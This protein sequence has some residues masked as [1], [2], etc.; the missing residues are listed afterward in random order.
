M[1][2]LEFGGQYD[3]AF[4]YSAATVVTPKRNLFQR[5]LN[6][7]G[8][9]LGLF[10]FPVAFDSV[11]EHAGERKKVFAEIY[12][13]NVWGSAESRSGPGSE[14]RRTER[15]RGEL[16]SL[17]KRREIRSMFDA[18]CGDLNW[19]S[20]VLDELPIDY[21]GGDI[22]D[23]ALEA[24]RRRRPGV[25]VRRFDICSDPFPDMQLWHC[26]DSL[27][28]LSFADIWL[29]F[30]NAANSNVE[31]ALMTTNRARLLTNMD[32]HT[33]G[34]RVLDL[35]RAPFNLPRPLEYLI[36]TAH[37]R[38]PRFVG[39]WPIGALSDALERASESAACG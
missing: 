32:I 30:R 12:E 25:Q 18:P 13:N 36:D 21:Q 24:A 34:C 39:L 28:H 1:S 31:Y 33:G 19:M 7:L 37:D 29:A 9:P 22:S 10:P 38:V 4:D 8:R 15:Y 6:R 14:I 17:L 35:E 20:L 26:R 27:F 16:V 23:A 5:A 11:L 2:N 3:A